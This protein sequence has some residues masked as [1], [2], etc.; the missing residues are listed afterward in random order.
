MIRY[1]S[2]SR[3]FPNVPAYL[4]SI[5]YSVHGGAP[6]VIA[7]LVDL[8]P[9]EGDAYSQTLDALGRYIERVM[10]KRTEI[11]EEEGPELLAELIGGVMP[12]RIRLL[13][14]R[15]AEMHLALASE[16]DDADFTPEPFTTLH[17]RSLYQSM[18]GTTRR[19]IQV[20]RKKL[21]YLAASHREEAT[22]L[23]GMES[24]MLSRQ[25]E[26]LDHKV[27]V[28]KIRVHGDYHLGQVLSTGKDFMI[29]DFEG[30]PA[31]SIGER[32]MKRSA[33][34][35]VA[36][37]LRSFHYA[38]QTACARHVLPSPRGRRL[39][40]ALDGPMGRGNGAHFPGGVLHH[41]GGS[42]IHPQRSRDARHAAYFL[43]P[44]Q[45]RI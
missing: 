42:F 20:L 24:D 31:R 23:L 41:R 3:K 8:V 7:L 27:P 13:G 12:E 1:L 9:N 14:Q 25:A 39:P 10:S 32:R 30:E 11:T 15:T 16:T 18:R 38:A 44:G 36:G 37:M 43:S 40:P 4:G 26:L 21:P 2:E 5:E 17:Q 45:G 6:R 35:D 34:V 28:M 19:M 22:E 29:I 33:L